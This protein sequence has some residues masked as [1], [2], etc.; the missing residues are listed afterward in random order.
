MGLSGFQLSTLFAEL[1]WQVEMD[2]NDR[3]NSAR[4]MA[5]TLEVTFIVL[6]IFHAKGPFGMDL[7]I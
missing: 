5:F 1:Y 4:M 3:Q 6:P 2:E 7:F